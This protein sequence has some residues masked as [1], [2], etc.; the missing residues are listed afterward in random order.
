V[1]RKIMLLLV[2]LALITVMA[3]A[4]AYAV[5]PGHGH[6]HL[7]PKACDPGQAE[8]SPNIDRTYQGDDCI[9]R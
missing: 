7:N 2:A 8:K 3:A 1:R 9:H 6:I 4:P 5:L